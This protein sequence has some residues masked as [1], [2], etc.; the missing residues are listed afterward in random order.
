MQF[1][2]SELE[3]KTVKQLREIARYLQCQTG[4][5]RERANKQTLID[6]ILESSSAPEIPASVTEALTAKPEPAPVVPASSSG[7]LASVLAGAIQEHLQ[8]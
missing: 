3:Q 1:N 7:D 2:K 8:P 6:W 5:A 4:D